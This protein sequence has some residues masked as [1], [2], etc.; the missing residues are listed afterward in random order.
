ML[1]KKENTF[2]IWRTSKEPLKQK[3]KRPVER[4]KE[5][6]KLLYASVFI[7]QESLISYWWISLG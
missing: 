3:H 5:S 6:V 7:P 1:K 4:I 2:K